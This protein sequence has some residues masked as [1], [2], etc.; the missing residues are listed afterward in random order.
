MKAERLNLDEDDSN[1]YTS[2]LFGFFFSIYLNA[3]KKNLCYFK[4]KKFKDFFPAS[5]KKA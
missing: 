3:V 5:E 2:F 4:H 1:N